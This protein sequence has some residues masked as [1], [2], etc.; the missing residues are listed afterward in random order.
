VSTISSDRY[1]QLTGTPPGR[2][3][4]SRL[5]LPEATPLRRYEPGGPLLNG[6]AVVLGSGRLADPVA[7]AIG[8]LGAETQSE[9]PQGDGKIGAV[10]FDASGITD[11]DGLRALYDALHPAITRLGTCGRLVVLG[12]PPENAG[13]RPEQ[14]AQRALE[15]FTRSA[16]KELRKGATAQLVYVADGAETSMSS[17]LQFLLSGRSA[18]VDGQVIRI[19]EG[20]APEPK[21]SLKPLDGRT[22]VVT[23]ASRG[24]GEQMARTLARDGATV[25]C[26]DVQAQG[27]DLATVANAIGGSALA[28]DVTADDAGKALVDYAKERHGSVDILV[29][30]AGITRDKTLARMKPELWDAVL[31]VNLASQERMLEQMLKAKAIKKGARVI[32]VSSIAG[33]AGNRGQT[34]YGTSKAGVIGL[35]D[36]YAPVLAELGAT[37]NAVAPGFIETQMTAAVPLMIREAGRRMNSLAQGGQPIDVAETVAWYAQPGSG[38]VNGNVVRVCG[39]SLIGA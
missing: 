22:A 20:A 12:S 27:E 30:N 2:F 8:A 5:G 33:I 16:A 15:G 28:L 39:Q 38:A 24:I 11:I 35:V 1:Q 19:G 34:N 6:A 29:L 10:L 37:I 36:A 26:V 32:T 9:L 21:D 3:L 4:Q 7:A 25:I 14:I 23:G 17:T 13:S 18:Y 31:N